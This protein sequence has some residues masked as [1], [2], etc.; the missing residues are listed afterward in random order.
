[1]DII[2]EE[3]FV[4]NEINKMSHLEMCKLWRQ[5]PVGHEYFDSTLPYASVFQARL[6]NHFGGFTPEI[7]KQIGWETP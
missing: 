1:M 4:I 6:F 5:A 7:S 2:P 3:Q